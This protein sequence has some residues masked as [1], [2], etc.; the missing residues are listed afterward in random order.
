MWTE[1]F[2]I[3]NIAY[4]LTQHNFTPFTYYLCE[5]VC[6]GGYKVDGS[7]ITHLCECGQKSSLKCF[8]L[9]CI[10]KTLIKTVSSSVPYL[11]ISYISFIL[12]TS[13]PFRL[14]VKLVFIYLLNNLCSITHLNMT[15]FGRC[16]NGNSVLWHSRVDDLGQGDL[17]VFACVMWESYAIVSKTRLCPC[18]M[19]NGP[20]T[21]S[22]SLVRVM[23]ISVQHL[24]PLSG[25]SSSSRKHTHESTCTHMY[26]CPHA[27]I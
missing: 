20:S 1:S 27:R 22:A 17:G 23:L 9:E 4:Q 19:F 11:D 8:N 16:V 12:F 7:N 21:H 15:Q 14:M 2:I 5:W 24:A 3:T 25:C 6:D 13:M 18:N 10:C 26:M